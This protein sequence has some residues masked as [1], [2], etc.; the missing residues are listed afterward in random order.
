MEKRQAV[1]I[2]S[3]LTGFSGLLFDDPDLLRYAVKKLV[4]R[5]L[6]SHKD[7]GRKVTSKVYL[8]AIGS[9]QLNNIQLEK[10]LTDME[11]EAKAKKKEDA[12]KRS[13]GE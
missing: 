5:Y 1:V 11:E 2:D 12:L 4:R 13:K 7:A 9:L 8:A 3:L 6:E 10:E